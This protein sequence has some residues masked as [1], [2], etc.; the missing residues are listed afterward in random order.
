[1]TESLKD[2]ILKKI[3]ALPTLPSVALH[4][5]D[6]VLDKNANFKKVGEI[7]ET[8]Q[9]L[10]LKVLKIVN[11]PFYGLPQEVPSI[12][13]AISLLGFETLKSLVL[14]VSIFDDVMFGTGTTGLNKP[15]FWRHSLA[16]AAAARSIA[17]EMNYPAPEEAYAAGLLHDM[18]KVILD[19]QI[20]EEFGQVLETIEKEERE[21][22]VIEKEQL[23][24]NHSELGYA[25]A[26]KWNLPMT[27]RCTAGF[28]H[29]VPEGLEMDDRTLTLVNLI[30]LCDF[31][32]W[33]HGL[34]SVKAK[35]PPLQPPEQDI[36][37]KVNNRVID[38]AMLAVDEELT[39]CAKLFRF[40]APNM[41]AFRKSLQQANL[42][43]GKR[44]MQYL[45]ARNELELKVRQLTALN[46][47]IRGIRNT[48]DEDEISSCLTS[49]MTDKF[50]YQESVYWQVDNDQA[51]I[52]ARFKATGDQ[53]SDIDDVYV[54]LI[55]ESS[56]LH[57]CI[58][59]Q[60]IVYETL[61][62]KDPIKQAIGGKFAVLFPIIVNENVEGVL[63]CSYSDPL[64]MSFDVVNVAN[65]FIVDVGLALEK[66]HLYHKVEM[67]SIT[68]PLTKIANR[69]KIDEMLRYEIERSKR[70]GAP[71]SVCMF[72]IDHFK[73]FNDTY[74]HDAGDLILKTV[75]MI[76]SRAGRTTDLAGRFGGEEFFSILPMT[77]EA[78]AA[79]YAE[80]V[81]M[82]IESF[83]KKH[84]A[85]M[86]KCNLTISGGV[87]QYDSESD[88]YEALI[89]KTDRALYSAKD[90]GRNRVILWSDM[91]NQ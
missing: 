35:M 88:D 17:K 20:P 91:S 18:G 67:L 82:A 50:G 7:V 3:Q 6:I 22:L 32:V 49:S 28:H 79:I 23:G 9:S 71:L 15:I 8:D 12:T 48:F 55:A 86:P 75:A 13:H 61:T 16:V 89:K 60:E 62:N 44:N 25:L 84:K 45:E 77:R 66:A 70:Y 47:S 33:V 76:L 36:G 69:H 68:D 52:R 51:V 24:I 72:D 30:N 26:E 41:L 43:L 53:S 21:L 37:F 2:I 56:I 54:S 63:A 29:G 65:I 87:A 85:R 59:T 80:R 81:R 4:I 74:G 31:L 5:L 19:Q 34:G 90:A 83:G 40:E 38:K 78:P 46:S 11:S 10:S 1:M 14:S 58:N 27:L 42:E 57:K 39:K 73:Q 64:K